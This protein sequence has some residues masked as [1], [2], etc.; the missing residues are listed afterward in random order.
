MSNTIAE[1]RTT[2]TM[3]CA[4]YNQ[5]PFVSNHRLDSFLNIHVFTVCLPSLATACLGNLPSR[6]GF[7]DPHRFS[8]S[9][10]CWGELSPQKAKGCFFCTGSDDRFTGPQK[11]KTVTSLVPCFVVRFATTRTPTPV[12]HTENESV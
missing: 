7:P 11:Q 6:G 10:P 9:D 5:C 12:I 2:M 1:K 8:S 4:R 3:A